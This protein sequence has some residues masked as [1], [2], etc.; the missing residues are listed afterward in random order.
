MK[1]KMEKG[2]DRL[3]YDAK[4]WR[5]N[6]LA[7]F[8]QVAELQRSQNL[9]VLES[10]YGSIS[11][12]DLHFEREKVLFRTFSGAGERFIELAQKPC[13]TLSMKFLYS[14]FQ[15]VMTHQESRSTWPY[16]SYKVSVIIWMGEFSSKT[17]CVTPQNW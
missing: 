8:E 12:H 5:H 17:A 16:I 4:H 10:L 3:D 1:L 15:T 9:L 13:A 2:T 11:W 14:G 6:I 7:W